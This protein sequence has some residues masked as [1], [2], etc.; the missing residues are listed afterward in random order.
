MPFVELERIREL[1]ESFSKHS[2]EYAADTVETC[3]NITGLKYVIKIDL[4]DGMLKT[5]VA[6]S[7][8]EFEQYI[9]FLKSPNKFSNRTSIKAE[10]AKN[11]A[12]LILKTLVQQLNTSI[13]EDEED[14]YKISKILELLN[15]QLAEL[16]SSRSATAGKLVE[17][18]DMNNS[19]YK[20]IAEINRLSSLLKL[21]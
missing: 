10:E 15:F 5:H 19:L 8:E 7:D 20:I 3:G 11:E 16:K 2:R 18:T 6:Q 21:K 13:K 1:A 4:K 17:D 9:K 12:A 14:K